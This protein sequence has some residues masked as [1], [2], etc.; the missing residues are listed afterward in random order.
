MCELNVCVCLQHLILLMSPIPL[1]RQA[2]KLSFLALGHLALFPAALSCVLKHVVNTVSPMTVIGV[3]F[4]KG[5][6]WELAIS[7]VGGGGGLLAFTL[8]V[9][10]KWLNWAGIYNMVY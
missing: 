10:T 6:S 5:C 2:L 4:H 9:D 7:L 1:T 3:V 8:P